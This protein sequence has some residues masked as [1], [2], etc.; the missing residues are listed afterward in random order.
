MSA[1]R[2]TDHTVCAACQAGIDQAEDQ[3]LGRDVYAEDW[4]AAP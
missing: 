3:Q 4:A 1:C 2:C